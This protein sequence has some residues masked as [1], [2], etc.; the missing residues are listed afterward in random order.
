M[1]LGNGSRVVVA[2][3]GPSTL[4]VS[5]VALPGWK[6]AD[7]GLRRLVAH[8]ARRGLRVVTVNL[9]GM[10]VSESTGR[11][12]RG[13]TELSELVEE[14]LDSIG[15]TEPVVLVGH[16]FGATIG[17]TVASRRLAPLRGLVLVSPVV[18]RPDRRTG[19]SAYAGHACAGL[20]A[21]V[22]SRAPRPIADAVVGSTLLEDAGNLTLA[23]HGL[24]GFLR[25][26]A[27]AAP[28]RHLGADPRVAADHLRVA[29]RSGC[30]ERA[31]EVGIPTWIVAGDRDQLSPVDDLTRL[32]EALPHGR[33]RLLAGA[34]HLAHQEDA[35]ALAA[36]VA[37]CVAEA[38]RTK[39]PPA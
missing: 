12:H 30:L 8:T 28:E 2:D 33:L 34:G 22:M 3:S 17:V 13:L 16:S 27:E 35:E 37:D 10:G 9:P 36:L 1:R 25:I 38:V 4:P 24:R 32:C 7:L 29:S 20:F 21:S 26:R 14:V 15:A 6:G 23:R 5:V 18:V 39:I 11:L 31:G 19:L